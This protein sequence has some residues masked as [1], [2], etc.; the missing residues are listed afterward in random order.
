MTRF[1]KKRKFFQKK[2]KISAVQ[3][4]L[5]ENKSTKL[6]GIMVII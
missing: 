4:F 5:E 1:K 2:K 6:K 3:N